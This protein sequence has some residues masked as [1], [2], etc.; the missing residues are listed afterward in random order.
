MALAIDRID[1]MLARTAEILGQ[2][3]KIEAAV[4]AVK[5]MVDPGMTVTGTHADAMAEDPF[6][7]QGGAAIYLVDNANHCWIITDKPEA[8]RGVVVATWSEED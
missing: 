8:A 6:K 7:T 1:A 2:G 3:G 4:A 5:E